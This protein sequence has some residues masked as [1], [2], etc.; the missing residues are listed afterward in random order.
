MDKYFLALL[1]E[2]GAAGLAKGFYVRFKTEKLRKAYLQELSH[3]SHFRKF[4]RS[5]LELPVYYLLF[6][7]GLAVSLFGFKVS[8]RV[9][10]SA[11]RGAINFY[12]ENFSGDPEVT[13]ILEDER[14]H[15]EI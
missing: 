5:T 7:F 10:R 9:I 3:W 2:A 12:V 14:E 4:R 1:G 13:K 11:E 15:M 6:A 8:R